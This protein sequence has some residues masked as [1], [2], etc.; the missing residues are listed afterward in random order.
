MAIKTYNLSK[1]GN[2]Y[3]SKHIQVKELA[4]IGQGK[5][6]SNTVKID[7]TLLDKVE[8]LFDKMK[9]SK[10]IISSG[11]RTPAHDKNVGG[12]GSGAHTK[13]K[14]ID[15]CFYD[16]NNKIIS[17]KYVCCIAQDLGFNGIAN[18]SS[19][20][21]YVHLDILSRIYKG[22]ERFGTNTVTT[23]FYDYFDI[24]KADLYKQLGIKINTYY[25]KYTGKSLLI[26]T[27]LKSIKVPTKYI[28]NYTK[29]TPIANANGIKQYKGS[30]TQNLKLINLAKKGKLIKP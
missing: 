2:V 6:Y 19:N 14:A 9:C 5:T 15:C 13:G 7:T 16:K 1:K 20:Y 17:A 18:I 26:D 25:S 28:G 12:N 23:N 24:K 4:S 8:K 10:I 11:Y 3:A 27:V 29:R 21:K 22:D 30:I